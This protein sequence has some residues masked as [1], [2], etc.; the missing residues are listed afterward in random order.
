MQLLDY[1]PL[2][3]M[4]LQFEDAAI[5]DYNSL[6]DSQKFTE[7]VDM[8]DPVSI[9][10]KLTSSFKGT[11]A[12]SYLLSML[13]NLFLSSN[14]NAQESDDPG[15]NVQQL[16][17]IDSL[18]SN[19]AITTLDS[20]SNFNVA[21]QRLYDSM[22]TDEIAR[23]AILESRELTKKLEEV[24]AERDYLNDKISKAENGLVGQLQKELAERDL[25]LDKTQRVT[26][27]LQSELEELK[28]RHLLEKHEHEIELR[29]MLTIVNSKTSDDLES[30][31]TV[32]N[33]PK[34]LNPERKT[35]IQN[36]LQ[37]S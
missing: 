29:K 24:K 13:Q 27:Q 33:D 1:P 6:I 12:E 20:E 4:L 22:Q 37:R 28:K 11:E 17:L 9:L 14:K 35:A 31:S 21:I 2:S 5:D 36:V 16:K 7:N 15:K 34:P 25:I 30:G 8:D 19:V 23:R 3:T 32:Q 26:E 18:I 10:Q